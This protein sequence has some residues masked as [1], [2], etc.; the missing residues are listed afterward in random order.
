MKKRKGYLEVIAG[1]MYCGKT[2]ELIRQAK[3]ATIGKKKVQIFKHAIDIRYGSGK[4]VYSHAGQTFKALP[5]S[6]T[7]ELLKKVTT[8]SSII[9]IDEAQWFGEE[10]ITA[11]TKLIDDGKHVII[12]G[13]AL[14]YDRQPF[15]P[16]PQLMAMADKVTKLS[17]VCSICGNDAI[18]HKRVSKLS[19]VDPLTADPS[20]VA[21][22]NDNVFE[23][24]CRDCYDK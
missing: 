14:T 24:R 21:K 16:M 17:A 7:R 12:S 5:V 23:A 4:S 11:V 3:R 1:P 22:L 6:S 19:D 10:L 2:E 15:V 13:L 18:F 20:L 8:S 9:G